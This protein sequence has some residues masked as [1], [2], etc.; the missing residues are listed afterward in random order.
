[1]AHDPNFHN[2]LKSGLGS[3]AARK[4]LEKLADLESRLAALEPKE[5][6]EEVA[7]P[8]EKEEKAA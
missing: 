7:K 4:L 2:A 8:K 5:E 6:P 1:M 3:M